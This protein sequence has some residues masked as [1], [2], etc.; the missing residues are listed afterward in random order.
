MK[1]TA[2]PPLP[3]SKRDKIEYLLDHWQDIY[4]PDVSKG[5]P[6]VGDSAGA[7]MPFMAKHPSVVELA[8]CLAVLRLEATVHHSHLMAFHTA[9]WRIRV[10][11]VRVRRAGGK[12]ELVET[13]ERERLVPD[14]VRLE[15]VR[16]GQA[17]LVVAFRGPVFIPD[18][19]WD[20]LTLSSVEVD[21]KAARRL[22]G[23]VAA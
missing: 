9:V 23:R 11:H 5:R 7:T 4:D 19:L 18:D 22:R 6:G 16:R 21:A 14:W 10:D 12:Y 13:R 20:A 15:K 2:K 3:T 17:A 8:R 1:P